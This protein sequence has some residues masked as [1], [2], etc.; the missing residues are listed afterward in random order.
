MDNV[1]ISVTERIALRQHRDFFVHG[2]QIFPE[3]SH[4]AWFFWKSGTASC[5]DR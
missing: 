2:R 1:A 4:L 5:V 3:D